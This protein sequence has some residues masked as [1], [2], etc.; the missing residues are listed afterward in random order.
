MTIFIQIQKL[1]NHFF[2]S[3]AATVYKEEFHHSPGCISLKNP[4]EPP[5]KEKQEDSTTQAEQEH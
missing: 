5:C 3:N 2:H 1:N 4:N